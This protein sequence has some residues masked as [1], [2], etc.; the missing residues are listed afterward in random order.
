[1]PAPGGVTFGCLGQQNSGA[2]AQ[3][4]R[5]N[6]HTYAHYRRGGHI[7]VAMVDRQGL[8]ID[9]S[10]VVLGHVNRVHVWRGNFDVLRGRRNH[11]L[12]D[13]RDHGVS[14]GVIDLAGRAAG[15]DVELL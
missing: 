9:D 2:K 6:R 11:G 7:A 12:R 5:G 1:M 13:G 15:L 8:P 4:A 14:G 10:G 3:Y